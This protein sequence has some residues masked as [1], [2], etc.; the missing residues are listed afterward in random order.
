MNTPSE[1]VRAFATALEGDDQETLAS[2]CTPDGWTRG[3]Q[4]I[5]RFTRQALLGAL[6]FR[7]LAELVEEGRRAAICGLLSNATSG[8][9]HGRLWLHAVHD[10][11]WRLEG[12]TKQ[13]RAS[14]LFVAGVL[15][16]IF[17]PTTL[18]ESPA[19][20]TWAEAVLKDALS[21]PDAV[22]ERHGPR[23]AAGL[24]LIAN[25]TVGELVSIGTHRIAAIERHTAGFGRRHGP[26]DVRQRVWFALQGGSEDPALRVLGH[27][28]GAGGALLLPDP[29]G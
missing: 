21:A 23:V 26:D 11:Q 12:T 24:E 29:A 14:A 27:R 13:D 4:S 7:P 10:G 5:G 25:D 17:D 9:Q 18:P 20:A 15:P 16:A 8:R 1:L 3:G 19:A 6:R 2:L 22:A 28:V